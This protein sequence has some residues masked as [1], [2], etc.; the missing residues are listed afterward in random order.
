[1]LLLHTQ[2]T[3]TNGSILAFSISPHTLRRGGQHK[4]CIVQLLFGS[5]VYQLLYFAKVG[6]KMRGAQ[7]SLV[8]IVLGYRFILIW[9]Y[10]DWLCQ[11]PC[12]RGEFRPR[13]TRQLPRVVDLRG[14]LLSCQS[15]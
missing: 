6:E 1:M 15:Y 7:G 4:Y 10:P 5:S 12:H 3:P 14:R 2:W 11:P 13:Q 8:I 9:K